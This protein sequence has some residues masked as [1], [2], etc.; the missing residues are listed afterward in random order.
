VVLHTSRSMLSMVPM[1]HEKTIPVPR[2][3]ILQFLTLPLVQI[4][5]ELFVCPFAIAVL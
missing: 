1:P 2:P 5:M 3:I 4:P